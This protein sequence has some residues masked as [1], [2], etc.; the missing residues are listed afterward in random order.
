VR[1]LRPE[2]AHAHLR[3]SELA[4]VLQPAEVQREESRPVDFEGHRREL[5]LL[6][7][8]RGNRLVE[9]D[10]LP[11]VGEGG[12]KARASGTSGT[13]DDA[14]SYL[15]E[16]RPEDLEMKRYDLMQDINC[17]GAFLVSKACIPHLKRAANPHILT[18]S[19]PISLKPRWLA[20]I[21][22]YTIRTASRNAKSPC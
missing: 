18:L 3:R 15:V 16:G 2:L 19:P 20:P 13:P 9:L 21:V 14:E 17:R 1:R 4:V 11:A 6:G 12:L 10:P 22:G 5:L 8:E 7:L